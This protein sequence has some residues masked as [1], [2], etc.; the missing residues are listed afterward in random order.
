MRFKG[1]SRNNGSGEGPR[2]KGEGEKRQVSQIVWASLCTEAFIEI[3]CSADWESEKE[4]IKQLSGGWEPEQS[5][6]QYHST[7]EIKIG[8]QG[9]SKK[10]GG[11]EDLGKNPNLSVGI[12]KGL[13]SNSKSEI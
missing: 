1:I 5:Y 3:K 4:N 12:P 9:L 10:K 6:W 8:L 11:G 7:G 13:L 2:H